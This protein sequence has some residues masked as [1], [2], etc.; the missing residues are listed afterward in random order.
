MTE[1]N[2]EQQAELYRAWSELGAKRERERI[3]ELLNNYSFKEKHGGIIVNQDG[4]VVCGVDDKVLSHKGDAIWNDFQRVS[5]L[6]IANLIKAEQ[7]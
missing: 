1:L 2:Q 7:Q 3:I 5:T 6:V 4:D